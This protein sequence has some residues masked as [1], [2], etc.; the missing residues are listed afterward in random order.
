[1][2]GC[3]LTFAMLIAAGLI[4][5]TLWFGAL[6][7]LGPGGG[8]LATVVARGGAPAP[9]L[10][11]PPPVAARQGL[12]TPAATGDS[13]LVRLSEAELTETLREA[14]AQSPSGALIGN[15]RVRLAGG[16]LELTGR[17]QGVTPLPLDFRLTGRVDMRQG[18]PVLAIERLEGVGVPLPEPALRQLEQTIDVLTLVPVPAGIEVTRV[19]AGEGHVT[20]YGRRR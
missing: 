11:V 4:G 9:P 15:P 1:V 20:V 14:L 6:G 13:Q 8:P 18:Q 19:E 16:R 12:S 17:L 3:L 7:L 10:A 5:A 2:R